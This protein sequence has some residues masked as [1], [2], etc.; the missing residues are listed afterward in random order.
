MANQANE[1]VGIFS[2]LLLSVHEV[3]P[4]GSV[5]STLR[6]ILDLLGDKAELAKAADGWSSTDTKGATQ[7]LIQAYITALLLGYRQ[8]TDWVPFTLAGS[9]SMPLLTYLTN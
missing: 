7:A 3:L 8:T 9:P 6:N 5:N 2:Q 1:R 4:N